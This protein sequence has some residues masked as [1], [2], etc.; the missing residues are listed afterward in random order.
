MLLTNAFNIFELVIKIS[1]V[2]SLLMTLSLLGALVFVRSR[3]AT[4]R[5]H[6]TLLTTRWRE[7]FRAAYAGEPIGDS[8][9][10][11]AR[12]DWF[13]VISLY[14]QFH[15]VREN[16]RPRRDEIHRQLG[17]LAERI[18]LADH[19]TSLL[20]TGDDGDKILALDV[21][22]QIRDARSIETA[23]T[24]SEEKGPEL[25]RAAAH[26]LL[27]IDP[28][29]VGDFLQLLLLR[30]DWVASRVEMMLREVDSVIL[31]FDMRGA[32]E[33]ASEDTKPRLLDY[34]RFCPP[35]TAH[36]ICS[37]V[38][39]DSLDPETLAAA[40]RS[41]APLADERDHDTAVRF[42]CSGEPIV[43]LSGLRVLRR[44]V[45]AEDRDL[46]VEMLSNPDYWI[47]LR[48]AEAVVQLLP[49][50]EQVEEFAAGLSDRFSRDAIQQ[51]L[52]E[53]AMS[54]R[55]LQKPDRRE[56]SSVEAAA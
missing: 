9:P 39:A 51:V 38:L 2:L 5:R 4:Y 36:I 21:L 28:G 55:R 46:L 56:T 12:Q 42:T 31:G 13:T 7:I 3:N 19:A 50:L 15:N 1:V 41:L 29:F 44:C 53:K 40:L 6:Q 8:F 48:A 14:I 47:R 26:Y 24:L 43:A 52:A 17:M 45:R 34:V 54:A 18:G 22:G 30:D 20:Q 11:V 27:R 16:D 37:N 35:A 23:R 25:S 32:I 10:A 49:T 33:G